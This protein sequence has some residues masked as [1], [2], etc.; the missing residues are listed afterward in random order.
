VIVAGVLAW[1]VY[2]LSPTILAVMLDAR[3]SAHAVRI[4]RAVAMM[5]SDGVRLVADVYPVS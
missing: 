4:D 2:L 1:V 3:R 5:T